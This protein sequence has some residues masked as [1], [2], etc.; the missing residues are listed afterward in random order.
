MDNEQRNHLEALLQAHIRRL[1]KLEEQRATLGSHTPPHI[2][3]ELDDIRAEIARITIQLGTA[4]RVLPSPVS[5]FVGRDTDIAVLAQAL[6]QAIEQKV[7]IITCIR[8]MG[9]LGK[10]QLALAVAQ[11]LASRFPDGQ[12][13]IALRGTYDTSATP[14]MALQSAI[15]AFN[16]EAKLTDDLA[17]L[18]SVYRATLTGK[19]VLIFADD[20]R[21][22]SHVRPLLPPP[23]CALLITTRQ[24]FTLPGMTSLNL[25]TLDQNEAIQPLRVICP[26]IGHHAVQLAS[27][28]GYLPLAL[29]VSASLLESSDTRSVTRYLTQLEAARLACLRDPD[30]PDDPEA[31]VEASLK[32]SYDA[33]SDAAQYALCQ[34]SVFPVHFDLAAAAVV[35]SGVGDIEG[36]LDLLRRRSLIA[37]NAATERYGLHD[38]VRDFA[39][40]QLG[41]TERELA[42]R[43]YAVYYLAIAEQAEGAGEGAQSDGWWDRLTI[44]HDNLRTALRRFIDQDE[45][46]QSL[47]MSNALWVFWSVRG[48]VYEGRS[49][50]EQALAISAT[51]PAAL[52]ATSLVRLGSLAYQQGDVVRAAACCSE[53]LALSRNLKEKRTSAHALRTLGDIA[54]LQVQL[55]QAAAQ[56][57]ESIILYR[58]AADKQGV[59]L[60]LLGLAKVA[61]MQEDQEHTQMFL[62]DALALFRELGD[63]RG[64]AAALVQ[65]GEQARLEGDFPRAQDLGEESLQL[66]RDLGDVPGIASA[67][68]RLGEQAR[69]EGSF[70]RANGQHDASLLLYQ[71]A[72]RRYEESQALYRELGG[73]RGISGALHNLGYV[74]LHQGRGDAAARLF[75]ASLGLK[76][77]LKDRRGIIGCLAGLA[78]VA[79]QTDR[80]IAAARLFGVAQVQLMTLNTERVPA[81]QAAR[82]APADQAEYDYYLNVVRSQ[83]DPTTFSAAWAEGQ[84]LTVEQAVREVL[85]TEDGVLRTED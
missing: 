19:H 50:F 64:T 54:N 12:L 8:G 1:R 60:V 43:R 28:C 76:E 85:R 71:Q 22:P 10:T 42:Q 36:L 70:L 5:D 33:L 47:R 34:L 37:W 31:S 72:Q 15:R 7:P 13:H 14:V 9:G 57:H 40:A 20:A 77:E 26:R 39:A 58:E 56:Y 69:L 46:E 80:L 30:M 62:T 29:R 4:P 48:H 68:I 45:G 81:L 18:Q 78:A 65:L 2:R 61:R 25:E 67:L 27:L 79:S 66:F 82:F 16:P 6:S 63:K 51:A 35:V 83:L 84:A 52:R 41:S 17:Q 49:W 73:K 75:Q 21:D 3:T 23:G 55:D 44:E 59:A 32:L 24:R 11:R 74:E 53:G 38:L